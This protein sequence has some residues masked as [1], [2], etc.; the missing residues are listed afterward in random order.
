MATKLERVAAKARSNPKLRFTSLAHHIT[1]ESLCMNLNKIPGKTSPGVDGLTMEETKKGFR[2]WLEQALTSIHRQAYKAPPVRRVWIPK[3]GKKEKRPLGVPCINDRALQRSVADVLNAIYEQDF[4]PC[5]MGGRPGI[6][7]HNALSTFNEVVSGRKVSWV[8]EADLKN[9]FGSLDHGWL[10]RFVEHR[11]GDPGILNLI[12][13]WL[14]AGVMETGDLHESEEGTPQGGPVSVILSNLYL[15]YVLDLWFERKVKPCLK[16]EAWLIRY[17]DDFVVCFQ[18]RSDA[19]RFMNVLPRRLGKFGLKLEPDK[20]RLVEFGRFAHR[21]KKR[22]ETVY[23]PGFT[24][25]CTRNRKGNF[26][27]GRKTEKTRLWRSFE[28]LKALLRRIR[29]DPLH[30]Q[31]TAIN[32][33]LQGHYAYYGMGGNFRSLCKLYRFVERYWRKMLSKRCRKGKVTWEKFN[34]LKRI[35]PLQRPKITIPFWKMQSMSV[36]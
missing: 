11:V 5:S 22:P 3:P 1:P 31:L 34:H 33:R 29:H 26:M 17:V 21:Q 4:L 7:A 35:M 10:L 18:H 15:H 13:R 8:F 36:L 20:T 23:F 6:G 30:E 25:Y 24:H 19:E 14:K 2:Q 12:R 27:V 9:F 32:R 16:G 28:K